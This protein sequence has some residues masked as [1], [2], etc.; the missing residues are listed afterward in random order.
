MQATLHTLQTLD[1]GDLAAFDPGGEAFF[2]T[3]RALIGPAGQAGQE[4]FDF[5]VCSI[6]WIRREFRDSEAV[7]GRYR[8]IMEDFSLPVI[9]RHVRH[10][11]AQASGADWSEV[12][13]K[14]AGWF[15]W[16][17]DGYRASPQGRG[18]HPAPVATSVSSRL[19]HSAHEP[20]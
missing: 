15:R 19:P 20:S 3:V 6:A 8:L 1:G 4:T 17:S 13:G 11:V 5:D 14:L 7:C 9:E 10:R 16:E 2:L 12:A 18:P